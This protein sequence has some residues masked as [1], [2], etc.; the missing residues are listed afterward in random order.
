MPWY[1]NGTPQLQRSPVSYRGNLR[2]CAGCLNEK[3]SA[4]MYYMG[5]SIPDVQHPFIC[6]HCI[7]KDAN[8]VIQHRLYHFSDLFP[9]RYAL[10]IGGQPPKNLT[11][12]C[13][14]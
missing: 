13:R 5:R 11:K 10:A 4:N 8:I 9:E 6:F 1:E 7:R 12:C 3:D 14:Q 2:V